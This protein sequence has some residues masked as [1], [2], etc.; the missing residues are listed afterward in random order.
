VKR[1]LQIAAD[2]LRRATGSSRA[3]VR[4]TTPTEEAG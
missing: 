3:V 1:I 4:L 2:E